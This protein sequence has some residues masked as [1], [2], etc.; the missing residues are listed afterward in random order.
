MSTALLTDHY[1]LT[2]VQAALRSGAASRRVVFEVFARSLPRGRRFGVVAGTGRLLD[3]LA[4]FRFS[5]D[6]IALLREHA[7]VDETT[8]EWIADYRFTGHIDGFAEGEPFMAGTPVLVVEGTFAECVVLETLVLSV[9]NHDSAIAA[10]AARMVGAAAGRPC[11]EMGSRRTHEWAAVAAA[12]AAYLAGFASTSNLAA[13]RW[14]V[15]T[16]GTSAHAFT[17][18]HRDEAAAFAAQVDALGAGT[19]LLVDTYDVAAGVA[20]AVRAAG[21]ALGAVRIDSGDLGP[22]ASRVRAEL[23]SLGAAGTRIVA[24]SDLDEYLIAELASAPVD[25]YG[26]GTALV[27]GSG[28]PTAGFVYKLVELDGRPV[29]KTSVGKATRGGRKQVT[30]RHDPSG[31]AVADVVTT[32]SPASGVAP[33]AGPAVVVAAG[34]GAGPAAGPGAGPA[35]G[36]GAGPGVAPAPGIAATRPSPGAAARVGSVA[37]APPSGAADPPAPGGRDRHLLVP[38]VRDGEAVAGHTLGADSLNA[39][40][41]H[42][43]RA[44]AALPPSALDLSYGSPC[45]PVVTARQSAAV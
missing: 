24:T 43:H 40:R 7:V 22:T 35:A 45:L 16:T 19:T 10:A 28:A 41:D 6:D 42:H 36:P 32:V 18:A 27:T 3:A 4:S 23:D 15:P 25:A 11:I 29:A 39:A 34:P 8:L 5:A 20:A 33:A 21:S 2:M 9:L 31:R 13:R 26:V 30:R 14:G 17:L 12:R 38:L 44:M 37:H 1:E